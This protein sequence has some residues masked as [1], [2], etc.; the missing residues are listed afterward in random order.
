MTYKLFYF[1][2]DDTVSIKELKEN[3]E[4]R[5]YFPMMLRKQKL[6]KNWKDKPG[7]YSEYVRFSNLHSMYF[8]Y[9]S[10]LSLDLHGTV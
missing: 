10:H 6:P 1:L 7:K 9:Y 2:E 5:D 8:V 4:G 3:Q